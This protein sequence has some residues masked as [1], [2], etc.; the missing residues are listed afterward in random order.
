V[1]NAS[2]QVVTGLKRGQTSIVSLSAVNG[3][4][5]TVTRI[6]P[7]ATCTANCEKLSLSQSACQAVGSTNNTSCTVTTASGVGANCA[8]GLIANAATADQYY[9]TLAAGASTT[10][11]LFTIAI[12]LGADAATS[13][14]KFNLTFTD[15]ESKVY[16]DSF[17][18]E[19]L[20]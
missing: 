10:R 1:K 18:V 12:S 16:T 4:R 17:T 19:V 7:A 13:P 15:A 2:N 3:T 11:P 5:A 20:P 14:V 6:R 8:C 9:Q